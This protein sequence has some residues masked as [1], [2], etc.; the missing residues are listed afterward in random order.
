MAEEN[1]INNLIKRYLKP[2][3]VASSLGEVDFTYLKRAGKTNIILD[4]DET[5]LPRK[6]NDISPE[7]YIFINH[8]KYNGFKICL[9]SNNRHPLRLE[10]LGRTL[11]LPAIPLALKPLPFG[12]RK[13][14][15][16][17]GANTRNSA[18]IGDQ[19][20]TDVLGG[21]LLDILTVYVHPITPETFI[22]RQWMRQ[23]EDYIL[24]LN[25]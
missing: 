7:I 21:R 5:L 2:D 9:T 18:V 19:I 10:Y 3:M 24:K 8:L 1:I 22:P 16:L 13:A 12:F 15:R 11:N 4:L 14:M 6:M 20:F 17:L 25:V 23:L